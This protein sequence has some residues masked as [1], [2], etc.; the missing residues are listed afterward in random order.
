MV[1]HKERQLDAETTKYMTQHSTLKN[2]TMVLFSLVALNQ[3]HLECCRAIQLARRCRLTIHGTIVDSVLVNG[4]R[5]QM[6]VLRREA[7]LLC[8]SDGSQILQVKDSRSAPNHAFLE[9]AIAPKVSPWRA[10]SPCEGERRFSPNFGAWYHDPHFAHRREWKVLGE[11]EG[12]GTCDAAD[13]FQSE[14]ATRIVA[15]GGGL[16]EGRG[17]V[18][19]S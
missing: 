11:P 3:E 9:R 2:A 18:G 19:K 12:I 4:S 5:E 17:G 15:N 16:V 7:E 13:T 8:R 1:V 14:A 10:F 6:D